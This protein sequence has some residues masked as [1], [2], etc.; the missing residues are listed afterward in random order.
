M[1]TTRI[2]LPLL[3][4]LAI[5]TGIFI[6]RRMNYPNRPVAFASQD[7]REQKLREIISYIDYDYVDEVNTDSLLDLTITDLLH[8]LDPHSSYITQR[9]V[10]KNV[11]S[12]SGSFDGVGIEYIINQ[13]TL[14]ILRVVPNGPSAKA[15][16]KGGDRLLAID[17]VKVAGVLLPESEY[18]GYLKGARGSS[19]DVTYFR[20]LTKTTKTTKVTRDKIAL[21]SIDVAYMIDKNTGFIKINRFAETTTSEFHAAIRLLKK[22]GATKLILDLRDN[23]G[24]LLKGAIEIADAFLD[25]DQLI[26]YTENRNNQTRYT[27]ATKKGDFIK[28]DVV[29]LINENSASASEI[30]AGALQDNDRAVLVGRRSFGKG[31]VQEEIE[32]KDGSRVRLTTA[33][34]YTPTGRSIQKPYTNGFEEYQRETYNR[35]KNGELIEADSTVF[36][37]V[38]KFTTPKGKVVYGGG[39]IMPDVFVPIDTSTKALGILY[40][41]FSLGQVDRFAFGYVDKH[42]QELSQWQ[43]DNFLNKFEITDSTMKALL[44]FAGIN[45]AKFTL[46]AFTERVLKTR[47]KAM[48][49]R[50]IWGDSG[51]YPILFTEDPMVLQAREALTTKP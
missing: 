28:G 42:R 33:R 12:L 14:V 23:P 21:K 5:A 39:G 45:T 18:P 11:E 49:A 35:F 51:M 9:D 34:Y 37:P 3:L 30:V 47:L 36:E 20:P 32:L 22:K 16:L 26:V 15:G 1:K 29:V 44:E 27:Y 2:Y 31:L 43:F 17:E 46:D 38:Q 24:G 7:M 6:G 10:Q 50:N 8:K 41:Y 25:K 40:H 48:I 19:I 4:A 13:D